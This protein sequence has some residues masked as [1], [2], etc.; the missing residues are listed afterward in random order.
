MTALRW[1]SF[2]G[3]VI[4]EAERFYVA[5]DNI[6]GEGFTLTH[7]LGGGSSHSVGHVGKHPTLAAAEDAAMTH[8]AKAAQS[9]RACY[10]GD[11]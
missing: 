10:L 11:D 5:Y 2:G 7:H 4:D 1:T 6:G 9:G 8:L 3:F